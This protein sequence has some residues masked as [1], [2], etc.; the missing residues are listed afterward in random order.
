M[1]QPGNYLVKGSWEKG[2]FHTEHVSHESRGG[3]LE[4]ERFTWG[5]DGEMLGV[6]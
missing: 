4:E 6:G 3:A 5:G 2:D 1:K